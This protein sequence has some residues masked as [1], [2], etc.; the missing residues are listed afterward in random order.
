MHSTNV[1]ILVLMKKFDFVR[2]QLDKIFGW[3]GFGFGF[4]IGIGLLF[5]SVAFLDR[6]SVV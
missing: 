4:G 6:K 2:R 5:S 1:W 3:M